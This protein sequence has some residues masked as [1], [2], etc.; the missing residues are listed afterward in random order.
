MRSLGARVERLERHAPP[1][2]QWLTPADPVWKRVREMHPDV[3]DRYTALVELVGPDEAIQRLTDEDLES[4]H[5]ALVA[6]KDALPLRR[7]D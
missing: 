4:L 1:A 6:A 2:R 5:A 3:M 7:G